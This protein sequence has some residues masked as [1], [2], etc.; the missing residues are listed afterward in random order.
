MAF[1]YA[2]VIRG[3]NK[4]FVVEVISSSAEAFGVVVPIPICAKLTT[5]IVN[6]NAISNFNFIIV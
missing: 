4:P 6:K 1:R 2:N 5:G 3:T